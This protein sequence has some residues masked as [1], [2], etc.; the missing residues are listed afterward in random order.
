MTLSARARNTGTAVLALTLAWSQPALADEGRRCA[1]TGLTAHGSDRA[2]VQGACDG[3]VDA[4]TFL[5]S[6]GLD[7]STP[8]E[9]RLVEALP[10]IQ[11]GAAP[12]TDAT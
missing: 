9:I 3:A 7:T 6:L 4:V 10:A 2:E 5:A 1:G 8:G 11:G 12:R